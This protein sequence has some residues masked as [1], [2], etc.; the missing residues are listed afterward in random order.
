MLNSLHSGNRL[1]V[2]FSKTPREIEIP[3][4]LQ[5]QQ[6]SYE[7]FLMLG[8]KDRRNSTLEKVFKSAFPIHDQQNRLTLT[9]KNSEIIKPKYTV[10][11][12]ME[13]GLTYSVS[14]KMNVALTIWNR[15]EKTGEKL[16]PK[17]IKEQAVFVRDIPLMTD[18]TS[19]VVN[20]VERVIVNQLHRSP[21]VIFKEEEGT[22]AGGKLLYSAQII[23]DRGSWLY[24]EYD[25]KDIL[26]ARINKRRKIPVTIL[27]RAL[28]YSKDDIIKLFYST[29]EISIKDNRFLIKFD[30]DDFVGRAEYDVKDMDGKT[31][32]VAGKRLTKKKAQK[33]NR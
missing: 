20:G 29:K 23:P 21:G 12:C 16:D 3:N 19:F 1:R 9:Y 8:E 5:L 26:Y 13:R 6:K 33:T 14:L 31:I 28:D 2:D 15:D 11:E 4:L 24:F 25:A 7:N 18:R 17:E 22:T 27:F 10:R 32:V 30:V